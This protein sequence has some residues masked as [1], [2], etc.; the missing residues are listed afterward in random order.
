MILKVII[1]NG[2]EYSLTVD[3]EETVL[4]VKKKIQ[5]IS[6][7]PDRRLRIIYK[8]KQLDD[9]DRSLSYYHLDGKQEKVYVL[10]GRIDPVFIITIIIMLTKAVELKVNSWTTILDVKCMIEKSQGIAV[11]R[12]CIICNGTRLKDSTRLEEE[13]I[14]PDDKLFLFTTDIEE[15]DDVG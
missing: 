8:S 13:N 1:V 9:H 12:Q 7:I 5:A 10:V 4:D 14:D 6:N 3:A 2:S 15:R 11:S